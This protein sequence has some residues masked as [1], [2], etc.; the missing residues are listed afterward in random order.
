MNAFGKERSYQQEAASRQLPISS[1][2][3]NHQPYHQTI[4]PQ[5]PLPPLHYDAQSLHR[6]RDYPD[7]YQSSL[8]K[9][10]GSNESN[11]AADV[12]PSLH[13]GEGESYVCE[14]Q[15]SLFRLP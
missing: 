13:I 3:Q 9:L 1:P 11:N 14:S 12:G 4:T 7:G 10:P 15:K 6:D 2:T 8:S 5:V